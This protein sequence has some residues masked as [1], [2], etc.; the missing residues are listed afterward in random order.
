MSIEKDDKIRVFTLSTPRPV[1]THY[2]YQLTYVP[3]E[4]IQA[5]EIRFADSLGG[6]DIYTCMA[7]GT[8][9]LIASHQ[10]FFSK[11][12]SGEITS[13]PESQYDALK[14]RMIDRGLC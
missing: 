4:L 6:V 14:S 10:F 11:D 3:F 7:P 13:F 1:Q 8:Y 2:R 12:P 9:N 5:A